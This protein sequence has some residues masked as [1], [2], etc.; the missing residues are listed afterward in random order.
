MVASARVETAQ[1]HAERV[2]SLYR[3]SWVWGFPRRRF[4]R[5][6]IGRILIPELVTSSEIGWILCLGI[7]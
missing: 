4:F 2:Q 7:D 3:F 1:F 6:R 5:V